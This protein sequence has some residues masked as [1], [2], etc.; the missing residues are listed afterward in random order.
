M[1]EKN[2][3]YFMSQALQLAS[4]GQCT[5]SPNPMVGCVIVQNDTIVGSGFHQKAGQPHAEIIALKDAGEKS[6]NAL[7]YVTLEPCCH[8]GK[9]PPCINAIIEAG[10]QKVIV[11]CLDPNP[12][13]SGKGI[14]A[15]KK[16][17]IAVET[18]INE[19]E[20]I[21]LN[22]I[23]F[24]YIKHKKPFVI[25]KWAMSLDGKTIVN[26]NDVKQISGLK[27]RYHTHALRHQVDAILV[28]AHT[29]IHDDPQLS[30]R[31]LEDDRK[32]EKQPTRIILCGHHSLPSNLKIFN[33]FAE[34]K[35]ILAVTEKTSHLFLHHQSENTEVLILPETDDHTVSLPDLLSALGKKTIASILVEGGMSLHNS[36][37]KENLV[38][39]THVY[40]SPY[41]IGNF[42]HKKPVKI[43]SSDFMGEDFYFNAEN[44]Y[45]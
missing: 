2:H 44:H 5:V 13:V 41:F 18:G 45:V 29:A 8:F 36:F 43:I 6:R 28:G 7:M 3:S 15:L 33:A 25:S 40:L 31:F 10:I 9:T 22:K 14:E 17:G 20:A 27:S 24:H 19:K 1:G 23:F 21:Q 37:F 11:A 30:V 39:E 32:I 38:N 4:R 35:T 12:L 42:S 26:E 34:S 16:A